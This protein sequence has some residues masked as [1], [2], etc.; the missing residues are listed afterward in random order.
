MDRTSTAGGAPP[1]LAQQ[2]AELSALLMGAANTR[3]TP[4]SPNLF[5]GA[6]GFHSVRTSPVLRP[7]ELSDIRHS[8]T[9]LN[10]LAQQYG[11]PAFMDPASAAPSAAAS[12]VTMAARQNLLTSMAG[13]NVAQLP[14]AAVDS[15]DPGVVASSGMFAPTAFAR[16]GPMEP[17]LT[18]GV[19]YRGGIA[20]R[21][22]SG[23]ASAEHM[24]RVEDT[25][26]RG[27]RLELE[28]IPSENAKSRVETQIKITVR[29][30]TQAGERAT[31]WT[32]LALPELL[33]SRDKFR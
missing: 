11:S 12:P 32:H 28:G 8:F 27:L 15:F 18:P 14:P 31:C 30:T 5:N 19:G 6:L 9:N 26:A 13:L 2:Q 7:T 24:H 25:K 17:P 23:V 10:A 29:L 20:A 4:G 21:Q 3:S 22:S 33:V 16:A 1:S